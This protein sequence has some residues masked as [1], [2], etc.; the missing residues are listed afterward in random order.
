[1]PT[2]GPRPRRAAV[3]PRILLCMRHSPLFTPE[4][5]ARYGGHAPSFRRQLDDLVR[6]GLLARDRGR[7]PRSVEFYYRKT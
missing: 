7:T 6:R 2:D 1:M 4:M 3:D 5:V